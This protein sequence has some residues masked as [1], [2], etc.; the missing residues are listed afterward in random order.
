MV[1][2]VIEVHRLKNM[3]LELGE[4]TLVYLCLQSVAVIFE[5]YLGH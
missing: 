4:I 1:Y 5:N 3:L 2:R